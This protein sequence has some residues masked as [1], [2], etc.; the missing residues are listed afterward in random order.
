MSSTETEGRSE[1]RRDYS[2]H[3]LN[4][5]PRISG[6]RGGRLRP[7]LHRMSWIIFA[8]EFFRLSA[9]TGTAVYSCIIF[10]CAFIL[11]TDLDVS[12][13][14]P[15]LQPAATWGR[16]SGASLNPPWRWRLVQSLISPDKHEAVW[17]SQ[18]LFTNLIWPVSSI[19][20]FLFS[21]FRAPWRF[22]S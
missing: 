22:C 20:G 14:K 18:R 3:T 2:L 4:K 1:T 17:K 19:V 13:S 15:H 10:C 8:L 11:H 7:G 6:Y 5:F 9:V 12:G 21:L 16:L